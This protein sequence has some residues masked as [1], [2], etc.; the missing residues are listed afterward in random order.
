MTFENV[1]GPGLIIAVV[2]FVMGLYL[3]NELNK[4]RK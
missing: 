1:V 2:V 4:L 3:L